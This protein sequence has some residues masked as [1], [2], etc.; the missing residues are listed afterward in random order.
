MGEIYLFSS[1]TL[2]RL[3]T[4]VVTHISYIEKRI[5]QNL[6]CLLLTISYMEISI[7]FWQV[8]RTS[9]KVV[10]PSLKKTEGEK[11]RG[12]SY[13]LYQ[14][15]IVSIWYVHVFNLQLIVHSF[16]KWRR[17]HRGG[18]FL[19]EKHNFFNFDFVT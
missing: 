14:W 13:I 15:C 5:P 17:I 9:W 11:L 16:L 2:V 19:C 10:V 6:A 4:E 18:M 12:N 1:W 8:D 7:V 3:V